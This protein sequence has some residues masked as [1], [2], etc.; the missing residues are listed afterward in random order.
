MAETRE[1]AV[2]AL[3]GLRE[4]LVNEDGARVSGLN[5]DAARPSI[6]WESADLWAVICYE[7]DHWSVSAVWPGERSEWVERDTLDDCLEWLEAQS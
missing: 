6:E 3:E 4:R 2:R 5:A 1:E 7:G